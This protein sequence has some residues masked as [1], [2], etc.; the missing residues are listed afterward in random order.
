[1]NPALPLLD[2][3]FFGSLWALAVPAPEPARRRGSPRRAS[4]RPPSAPASRRRKPVQASAGRARDRAARRA[5]RSL[6]RAA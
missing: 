3:A 2:F 5:E 6:P 1:M 4:P